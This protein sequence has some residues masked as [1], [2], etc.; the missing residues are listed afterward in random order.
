MR[1]SWWREAYH[2]AASHLLTCG[3]QLGYVSRQLGHADVA[4]TAR[5]YAQ[6]IDADEY[7]QPLR[8]QPG[9]VLAD[10]LARLNESPQSPPTNRQTTDGEAVGARKRGAPGTTRTCDLQVRNLSE[11]QE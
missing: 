10:L 8:V 7:R 4:V 2:G 3:V 11:A 6:W 9:E 1:A 5:H